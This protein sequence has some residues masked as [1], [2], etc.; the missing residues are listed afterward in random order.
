MAVPIIRT[1]VV[2]RLIFV[3]LVFGIL[4]VQWQH[5]LRQHHVQKLRAI[6]R[7]A[8]DRDNNGTTKDTATRKGSNSS[9]PTRYGTTVS[10]ARVRPMGVFAPS[11]TRNAD[12]RGHG[13]YKC[14][15][16]E[17]YMNAAE[18][19]AVRLAK[20]KMTFN[21][22]KSGNQTRGVTSHSLSPNT[23]LPSPRARIKIC[24]PCA[25]AHRNASL[26]SSGASQAQSSRARTWF[27]GR[28]EPAHGVERRQIGES[29]WDKIRIR[30]LPAQTS[31]S[32]VCAQN[33]TQPPLISVL[34]GTTASRHQFWRNVVRN[35][36]HQKYPNK[37]LIILDDG[38]DR[39]SSADTDYLSSV[40]DP[41]IKHVRK[42]GHLTV[43][44][45]HEA[46]TRAACGEYMATFDDDD[47]YSPDYLHFMYAELV[48]RNVSLVKLGAWPQLMGRWQTVA[49]SKV[50]Q[51][52][53]WQLN[54]TGSPASLGY[55]FSYFFSRAA[56]RAT[57]H[58]WRDG[59][60]TWDSDWVSSL[61]AAGYLVAVTNRHPTW[62]VIKIQHG[63][64]ES[65]PWS[66]LLKPLAAD[67]SRAKALLAPVL[68]VE[69]RSARPGDKHWRLN[70]KPP[71]KIIWGKN[72][73]V[74]R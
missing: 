15:C 23:M 2:R 55:G 38:H 5:A 40:S 3:C 46:L 17:T 61:Q 68:P 25:D 60:V 57:V 47:Y 49:G 11:T 45:K 53:M 31:I 7:V 52:S 14:L 73:V 24:S 43:P 39:R 13:D 64:N 50:L 20:A 27:S 74:V 48:A 54:V 41:R 12:G 44:Q 37:E 63:D 59:R 19:S 66:D 16:G 36:L 35:F 67:A 10:N 42:A 8:A 51:G 58:I 65:G 21:G 32:I 30:K 9:L 18:P 22:A 62:L 69:L 70:P 1:V 4:L 71:A 72:K 26:P 33:K 56:A 6:R 28:H 29:V 34:T